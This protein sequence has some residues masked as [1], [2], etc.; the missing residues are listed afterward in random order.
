MQI[1]LKWRE[2]PKAQFGIWTDIYV[3]DITVLNKCGGSETSEGTNDGMH[4][5][6]MLKEN[7][8]LQH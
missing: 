8:T 7:A 4:T 2:D 1:D 3:L 5:E 6:M